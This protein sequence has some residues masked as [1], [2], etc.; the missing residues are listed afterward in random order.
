MNRHFSSFVVMFAL[1]AAV[2]ACCDKS[3]EASPC[4]L[5]LLSEPIVEFQLLE[6]VSINGILHLQFDYDSQRRIAQI[7]WFAENGELGGAEIF[8]YNDAGNLIS[9]AYSNGETKS[10]EKA[11]NRIYRENSKEKLSY[12]ELDEQGRITAE[13]SQSS[14]SDEYSFSSVSEYE[15]RDGNLIKVVSE[16]N[17]AYPDEA[18]AIKD[19]SAYV[20]D[21]KKS[22][23]FHCETPKWLLK[24]LGMD[25]KN[26]MLSYN[27]ESV[28]YSYTYDNSGFALTRTNLKEGYT[29]EYIYT[30]IK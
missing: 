13:Y 2:F 7:R 22:P 8:T 30:K 10:F 25:I 16:Q 21:D 19:V 23:F 18:L 14:R 12:F 20:Y 5:D 26:N 15:Y 17:Y 29:E 9:I 27:S 28:R 3:G 4:A 24:T 11:G 1:F 6:T